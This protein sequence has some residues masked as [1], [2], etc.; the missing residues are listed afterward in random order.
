MFRPSAGLRSRRAFT[1][2]ELLVVIAII[3]IL[4]GLLLPAV[5]KVREAANRMKCQ[6]NLKQI[7]LACHN[8]HDV[9]GVLPYSYHAQLNGYYQ[10]WMVKV[11]PYIEQDRA[12]VDRNLNV[13][14][15]PSDPRGGVTYTG[16]LGLGKW[17]L[18]W[19]VAV[20]EKS[21]YEDARGMIG[22]NNIGH[23]FSAV[24]DG[25]SNTL[26]AVERVPNYNLYWGWWAYPTSPDTRTPARGT[27]PFFTTSNT[28]PSACPAPAIVIQADVKNHCSFNAPGSFHPGGLQGVMGD[29]SVR[30]ITISGA[31]QLLSGTTVSVIQ[32]LATRDAGELTPN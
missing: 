6:N 22:K 1:L 28:T 17:G 24:T 8:F 2:I 18:G 4:I 30:Y 15:C 26:M 13:S 31:N 7:G 23:P 27:S 14:A 20:D 25:L 12:A 29:G 19:Y 21:Y 32:A 9:N 3:A 16:N 10:M 11:M 5:Q